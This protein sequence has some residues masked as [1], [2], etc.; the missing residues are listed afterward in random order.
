MVD[1]SC[2]IELPTSNSEGQEE[3]GTTL[4]DTPTQTD[5]THQLEDTPTQTD[6]THRDDSTA[7]QDPSS[8]TSTTSRETDQMEAEREDVPSEE[9]PADNKLPG[10]PPDL[11]GQPEESGQ[12]TEGAPVKKPRGRKP[13]FKTAE[14]Q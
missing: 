11:L 10:Q 6:S 2:Y 3:G 4:E 12:P 9:L 14:T 13:K 1:V 5:S 7:D 8:Q